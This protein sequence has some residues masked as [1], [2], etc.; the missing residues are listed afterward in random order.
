[1]ITKVEVDCDKCGLGLAGA[2]CSVNDPECKSFLPLGWEDMMY[3][4]G[5]YV[6]LP[7]EPKKTMTLDEIAKEKGFE[8]EKEFSELVANVDI[9]T[10]EKLAA[11]KFWQLRDGSKRGLL[12]LDTKVGTNI[13]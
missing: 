2:P 1:M 6:F 4:N 9:T 11:F 8:N 13:V 7:P 5:W 3:V 10:P 12:E